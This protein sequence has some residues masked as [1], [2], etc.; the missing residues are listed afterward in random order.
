MARA[1]SLATKGD[2]SGLY[3]EKTAERLR[4]D[5]KTKPLVTPIKVRSR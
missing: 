1:V 4:G 2:P 5:E 3:S